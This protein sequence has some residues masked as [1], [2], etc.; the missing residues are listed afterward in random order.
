M[1][2]TGTTSS[3]NTGNF[4]VTYKLKDTTNTKWSDNSTADVVINWKIEKL[5]VTYPALLTSSFDY[6][7]NTHSPTFAS[8]EDYFELGSTTSAKNAG[9]Y[10]VTIKLKSPYKENAFWNNAGSDVYGTAD[11]V[12]FTWYINPKKITKPTADV[13]DFDYD[14]NLKTLTVKNYDSN[15]MTQSGTL[16]NTAAGTYTVTYSLKDKTNTAWNDDTTADVVIDWY[17]TLNLIPEEYSSGFAQNGTLTFNQAVQ[18]VKITNYASGY[19]TL[20]GVTSASDAGTY[21]AYIEPKAGKYWSDGTN[22]K[23]AVQWTIYK[24]TVPTPY[25]R[26][27][28]KTYSGTAINVLESVGGHGVLDS[29][30]FVATNLNASGTTTATNLG[31]YEFTL[32]LKDKNNMVWTDGTNDDITL[33]WHII[34][35]TLSDDASNFS[36]SVSEFEYTGSAI[37]ITEN[38]IVN[39]DS[40]YHK[41]SADSVVT[42]TAPGTYTITVEPQY[43]YIFSGSTPN[44]NLDNRQAKT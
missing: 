30:K 15:Y 39:F 9:E 27:P 12:N 17:I 32:S 40:T 21:T 4:S 11:D 26:Y 7:G 8:F 19:H 24:K 22:D 37:T 16:S 6:D 33:A 1:N 38:D 20:S 31:D 29:L 5:G 41:I 43:G 13:T 3:L 28:N 18:E 34:P 44:R 14:G 36:L 2:Q 25:V 23:K 10:T 42:A 35:N